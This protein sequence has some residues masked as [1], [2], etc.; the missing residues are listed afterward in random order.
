MS[1]AVGVWKRTK[2]TF[3]DVWMMPSESGALAVTGICATASVAASANTANN[4]VFFILPPTLCGPH[5]PQL[6]LCE[7][8]GYSQKVTSTRGRVKV[9]RVLRTFVQSALGAPVFSNRGLHL[10]L[11][12]CNIA[13]L[14]KTN[15]LGLNLHSRRPFFATATPQSLTGTER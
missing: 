5:L 8:K 7:D 12:P 3:E 10:R 15:G 4:P 6:S 11:R 1:A 9:T 2:G 13:P 14:L